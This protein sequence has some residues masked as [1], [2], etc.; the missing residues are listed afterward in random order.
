MKKTKKYAK[1]IIL[2]FILFF[3]VIVYRVYGETASCLGTGKQ[4][5][6]NVFDAAEG[7]SALPA[8][9][10]VEKFNFADE[11]N[12][13]SNQP[14]VPDLIDAIGIT[15]SNLIPLREQLGGTES[16][17]IRRTLIQYLKQEDPSADAYAYGQKLYSMT[18]DE[19]LQEAQK[20]FQSHP[21]VLNDLESL[22]PSTI[23]DATFSQNIKRLIESPTS[24]MDTVY[25]MTGD[26]NREVGA[27]VQ[28]VVFDLTQKTASEVGI[29]TK[30]QDV[31]IKFFRGTGNGEAASYAMEQLNNLGLAPPVFD[32]GTNFYV[33]GK[34]EGPTVAQYLAENPAAKDTIIQQYS[35]LI[36]ELA[37]HGILVQDLHLDNVIRTPEGK[38]QIIDAGYTQYGVNPDE[39]R[40]KLLDEEVLNN[41]FG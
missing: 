36:N 41:L 28:G 31:V 15:P 27:G 30:G 6:Q 20:I 12:K 23:D 21:E 18:D 8:G 7:G 25:A 2:A 19:V 35:D 34:V 10:D 29:D 33:V 22:Y 5:V 11:L 40:D 16:S 24:D 26:K 13:E 39:V 14:N 3:S 32:A 37:D 38:L 4:S 1:I 17:A 9:T